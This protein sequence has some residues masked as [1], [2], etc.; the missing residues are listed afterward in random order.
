MSRMKESLR[1]AM[2]DSTLIFGDDTISYYI[3]TPILQRRIST[4]RTIQRHGFQ[5]TIRVEITIKTNNMNLKLFYLSTILAVLAFLTSSCKEG[6]NDLTQK[7]IITESKYVSNQIDSLN[8]ALFPDQ[9]EPTRGWKQWYKKIAA[10][11][12]IDAVGA[13][14]GTFYSSNP[15]VGAGVAIVASA[16]A[17]FIPSDN[18]YYLSPTRASDDLCIVG[19]LSPM[20]PAD[21][22]LVN[23]VPENELGNPIPQIE[24]SIGY[25]HNLVLL[26]INNI[27]DSIGNTTMEAIIDSISERVSI[28]YDIPVSEVQ[29]AIDSQD[30]LYS[31][32]LIN[33]DSL[34]SN[35]GNTYIFNTLGTQF[36]THAQDFLIMRSFFNGLNNLN[37]QGNDATYLR[38]TL[39]LIQSSN[40]PSTTK[41]RLRDAFIVGNASYQ[42]WHS[43]E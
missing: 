12:I 43:E 22:S 25:Y 31:F 1:S 19:S 17:T 6:A 40:L 14:M 27:I 21:F 15:A 36:P 23:L 8:I 3:L 41:Q 10:I 30:S 18:I 11:A 33:K 7:S 37:V 35:T 34:I 28:Y 39:N 26:D 4:D 9:Y 38:Y 5:K 13:V 24:D 2:I 20:N 16:A 42:L 29:E 32:I